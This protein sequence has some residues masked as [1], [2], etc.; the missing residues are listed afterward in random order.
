MKRIE[1]AEL[2]EIFQIVLD[3]KVFPDDGEFQTLFG[4]YRHELQEIRSLVTRD[5]ITF[6]ININD[7]RVMMVEMLMGFP[8]GCEKLI[9]ERYGFDVSFH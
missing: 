3:Q 8:H 9:G 6:A 2:D 7:L 4:Y 5:D 1:D